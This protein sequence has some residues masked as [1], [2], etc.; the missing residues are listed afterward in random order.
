M[1]RKDWSPTAHS[2]ICTDH[3]EEKFRNLHP[4]PTIHN[5]SKSNPSL[6]DIM[7]T[8]EVFISWKLFYEI[9]EKYK[10]LGGNFKKAPK[11]T[12]SAVHPEN[13]KSNVTLVLAIFHEATTAAM[14][15]YFPDRLDA[16]NFLSLFHK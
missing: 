16:A 9:Q 3:F 7:N 15:S 14:K 5:D 2:V 11:P 1:N 10:K 4:V 13:N 12:Y 8:S 6:E